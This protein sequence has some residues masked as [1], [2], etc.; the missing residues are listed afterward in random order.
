MAFGGGLVVI[1]LLLFDLE[2]T[3]IGLVWDGKGLAAGA[4]GGFAVASPL[5]VFLRSPGR[6]RRIADKRLAGLS[7]GQLLYRVLIRIPFG[8]ALFEETVFRGVVFG[9]SLS[10]GVVFAWAVSAAAFGLWHIAPTL[11]LVE[12]NRPSSMSSS[13]WRAAASAVIV[14]AAA[15]IFLTLLR[16][17]TGGQAAPVGFHAA[18]NSTAATAAYLAHL[19]QSR[20]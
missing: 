9:L 3:D 15:G 11:N 7:I 17:E 13:R 5:F 4:I 12:I 19:A 20:V 6:S 8:T 16:V 18:L 1:S 14:T 2:P 10:Q